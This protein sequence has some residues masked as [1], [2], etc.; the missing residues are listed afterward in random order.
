MIRAGKLHV[1]HVDIHV[2]LTECSKLR[3]LQLFV[4]HR[5]HF[6][7]LILYTVGRTP[8]KR[9]QRVSDL[10]LTDSMELSTTRQATSCTA[11]RELVAFYGTR[12]TLS[13]F[14]SSIGKYEERLRMK[15]PLLRESIFELDPTDTAG[16][17]L[18]Q[19]FGEQ[20]SDAGCRSE[21]VQSADG[22]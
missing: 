19:Y 13:H 3:A 14:Y 22:W 18:Q 5:P 12:R 4:W 7:F 15:Q 1:V 10:C 9:D 11:T 20:Q 21:G 8:C 16:C 17:F 6:S 2:C